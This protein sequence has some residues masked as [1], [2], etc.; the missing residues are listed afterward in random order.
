M[1]NYIMT[2]PRF[3]AE[4][5]DDEKQRRKIIAWLVQLDEQL[6]YLM[7]NLDEENLS[8]G[9]SETIVKTSGA[10]QL[11]SEAVENQQAQIELLPDQI[12][13]AIAN[14]DEFHTSG[15]EI[16]L[17]ADEAKITTPDFIVTIL[18]QQDG[19]I[20][21]QIDEDGAVMKVLT[22]TERLSAPNMVEKYVG[23]LSITVG[24]GGDYSSLQA[25]V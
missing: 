14:I 12:S 19:S 4:D 3:T 1:P 17:T 5:F 18:T 2:R 24:T 23:P 15:S 21:L 9:L 7:G 11:V 6:R 25:A 10:I 13:I 16:V 22:V 20:A 8:Q